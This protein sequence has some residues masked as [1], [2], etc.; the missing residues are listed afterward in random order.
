MLGRK[1]PM[2]YKSAILITVALLPF[3]ISDRANAYN[4]C[5]NE[6]NFTDIPEITDNPIEEQESMQLSDQG[7]PGK[8]LLYGDVDRNGNVNVVDAVLVLRNVAGLCALDPEQLLAASVSGHTIST[9]D[10]ILILKYIAGLITVFPIG[11]AYVPVANIYVS[12]ASLNMEP[13]DTYQLFASISP[14]NASDKRVLW[15]TSNQSIATVSESGLVTALSPGN[16]QITVTTISDNKSATCSISI[17]IRVTGV[18]LNTSSLSMTVNE[19]AQLIATVRPDNATDKRVTWSSSN[20][21]VATVNTA[22]LVTAKAAGSAAITV[23]TSDG[24][25][26]A[27]CTVAVLPPAEYLP[28]GVYV[29]LLKQGGKALNLYASTAEQA[30][31]NGTNVTV[32]NSTGHIT[33]KFRVENIGNGKS[34][35]YAM[36]S[37]NGMDRLIRVDRGSAGSIQV[38]QNIQLWAPATAADQEWVITKV[39]GSYYKIEQAHLGGAV[40]GCAA[41]HS[42]G[43]NVLLQQYSGSDA[44]LWIA[45]TATVGN[46]SQLGSNIPNNMIWLMNEGQLRQAFDYRSDASAHNVTHAIIRIPNT[47]YVQ[48]GGYNGHVSLTWGSTL[49]D[50]NIPLNIFGKTPR[51]VIDANGAKTFEGHWGRPF[52]GNGYVGSYVNGFMFKPSDVH[53]MRQNFRVTSP[54]GRNIHNAWRSSGTHLGMD[55]SGGGIS[56]KQLY[57]VMGGPVELN[58][59]TSSGGTGDYHESYGIR[60]KIKDGGGNYRCFYAHMSDSISGLSQVNVNSPVG[61][62]GG[63]AY[64]SLSYYGAH[65]HFEIRNGATH[66]NPRQYMKHWLALYNVPNLD[67]INNNDSGYTNAQTCT[68][69]CCRAIF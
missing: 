5:M 13:G 20:S 54:F 31:N 64:G 63:S 66:V 29:F 51:L 35:I 4:T 9:N 15:E 67:G 23:V 14:D 49:T 41:P 61:W 1:L 57:S 7:P 27:G 2:F 50:G 48:G 65:L 33:Q 34:R 32:Y 40:M 37:S 16:A 43:G 12:P 26:T 39:S 11:D 55:F 45:D 25:K 42:D 18:S 21:S 17:V 53:T 59:W 69:G 24:N 8:Q 28:D 38:G 30:D 22:G 6:N 47:V 52:A 10:A 68:E 62:V 56:G 44:Q 60:I 36:A 3:L 58:G 46:T 19:T